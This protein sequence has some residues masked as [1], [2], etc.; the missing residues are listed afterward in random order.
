MPQDLLVDG[1]REGIA[2]NDPHDLDR[3]GPPAPNREAR[4]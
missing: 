2:L 3:L 1:A 4:I